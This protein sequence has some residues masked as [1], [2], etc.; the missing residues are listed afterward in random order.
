MKN[1]TTQYTFELNL[2]KQLASQKAI[3]IR[4]NQLIRYLYANDASLY[5]QQP[6]A[7]AFPKSTVECSQIIKFACEH[8]LPTIVRGGGTSLAGQVVGQVLVLDLSRYMTD[9][10]DINTRKSTA[11]VQPGV[12][13]DELNAAL[14]SSHLK[15]APDPSTQNRANIGGVIGNNAW[16]IH[17]PLYGSTRDQLVSLELILSN[18]DVVECDDLTS[19]QLDIKRSQSGLEGNIYRTVMS[20]L[21]QHQ[22]IIKQKYPQQVPNNMAYALDVMLQ[23]RPWNKRGDEFNLSSLI[24]GSEGS[25]GIVTE[26]TVKLVRDNVE[27]IVIAV[28]FDLM[29]EALQ[30]N[31]VV[32]KMQCSAVE[33][34][35]EF[36]LDAARINLKQKRCT[37]WIKG[38]PKAILFIELTA[39]ANTSLDDRKSQLLSRLRQLKLG[40]EYVLFE[41]ESVLDAWNLRRAGLGLLM[42]M[43]GSK[44]PI[45]FIEDS[46]VPIEQLP[47]FVVD[48]EQLMIKEN[49]QCVYYGSIAAGLI[50]LR[51][52]LDIRLELDRKKMQRVANRVATLLCQYK[53]SM[54]AKHGDGRV[55]APYIKEQLGEEI[56][57]VLQSIKTAFDPNEIFN[58]NSLKI[59]SLTQ[60]ASKQS[61]HKQSSSSDNAISQNAHSQSSS[62]RRSRSYKPLTSSMLNANLRVNIEFKHSEKLISYFDWSKQEG[63]DHV[64]NQCNGAAECRKR[65]GPGT[66]CPSYRVTREEQD[67]PRGRANLLRQVVQDDGG[68]ITDP[69]IHEVLELCISC[70]ACYSECP[71]N[72]DIARLKAEHLQHYHT[73][74]GLPLRVRF[75]RQLDFLSKLASQTSP[76]LINFI[77]NKKIVKK[78]LSLSNK[79]SLPLLA[80][81]TFS[82]HCSLQRQSS[83]NNINSDECDLARDMNKLYSKKSHTNEL[84]GKKVLLLNDLFT[85]YYDVQVGEAALAVLQAAGY[86]VIVSPCFSS[87]RTVLSQGLIISAKQRLSEVISYL[88]AYAKNSIPI[89]GLEPSEILTYRDEA[90]ALANSS[91]QQRQIEEVAKNIYYFDEFVASRD[92]VFSLLTF[93]WEKENPQF[94]LHGHCHQKSLIGLDSTKQVLS[95]IPDA[96]VTEIPSGC[97]GLAGLFGYEK[98]HYDLSMQ[99][100]ELVLFP[101]LRILGSSDIVV[102][103]GTS[104]RHQIAHAVK[105]IA[106]H[107]A[108]VLYKALQ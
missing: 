72:V 20:E 97:C 96:T 61:N 34:L 13:L 44:K 16:G 69:L 29:S 99:I 53:G 66:M 68:A 52:L 35:D 39:S 38:N 27:T 15:F 80:E 22:K 21:T 6:L 8:K 33:L 93:H 19:E 87:L 82:Q 92:E 100:G 70:K 108:Q 31:I 67:S 89:I 28:H 90:L 3:D 65:S 59:T 102:A 24:C 98:E 46:A 17:Y 106:L 57:T 105:S 12:T 4:F 50:H 95:L 5:Q 51:P 76:R 1:E 75:I 43:K 88:Y 107:P 47:D 84:V 42:G 101:A 41:G 104:C 26:A 7:V 60:D 11:R 2:L 56:L 83:V 81:K 40:Y 55:R 77:A 58:S 62:T 32:M 73:K 37:D 91:E 71:A 48:I 64:V 10:L 23:Q 18:G 85:E 78:L 103:T 45:T 30:T 54:S 74:Y 25:L 79:R 94:H 36:I 49:L 63:F 86:D 9:I 14:K